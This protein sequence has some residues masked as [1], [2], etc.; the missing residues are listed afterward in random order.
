LAIHSSVPIETL[1]KVYGHVNRPLKNATN[2]SFED[3]DVGYAADIKADD[4][5][6]ANTVEGKVING[7]TKQETID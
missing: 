2:V 7:H 5:G 4:N 6:T 1:R 3:E